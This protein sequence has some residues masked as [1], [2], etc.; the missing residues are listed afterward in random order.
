MATHQRIS[1][2][3]DL[4]KLAQLRLVTK[5]TT[6]QQPQMVDRFKNFEKE[7]VSSLLTGTRGIKCIICDLKVTIQLN[8]QVEDNSIPQEMIEDL[9]ESKDT[10][11]SSDSNKTYSFLET[12]AVLDNS[13]YNDGLQ[14]E[15]EDKVRTG[16]SK[17]T[18][19]SNLM[20]KFNTEL[21][22]H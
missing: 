14:I 2:S 12:M 22:F 19:L 5:L 16:R 3:E 8:K 15:D 4:K 7:T 1:I 20:I 10:K 11:D 18:N 21:T 17:R 6:K 9:K 13:E